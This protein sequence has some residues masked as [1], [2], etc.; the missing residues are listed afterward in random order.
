MDELASGGLLA[1]VVCSTLNLSPLLESVSVRHTTRRSAITPGVYVPGDN[2]LVLP[3]NLVAQSADGAVL[4]AGPESEHT[5]GLGNNHALL[6]VIGG[7]NALENLQSLQ[8]SSTARGLVG[9][10]SADGLVE[11]AGGGTEMPGT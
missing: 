8:R 2:V 6:L 10:H 9:D 1:L 3:A 4:A 7:R 5:E 11:D